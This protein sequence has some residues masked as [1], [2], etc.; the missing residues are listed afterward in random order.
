MIE[1]ATNDVNTARK[2]LEYA[3]DVGPEVTAVLLDGVKNGVCRVRDPY[4]YNGQTAA[5]PETK[6]EQAWDEFMAAVMKAAMADGTKAKK[7]G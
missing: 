6:D 5:I 4:M 2:Y 7:V 3:G 1:F